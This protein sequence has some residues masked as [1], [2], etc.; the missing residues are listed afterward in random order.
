MVFSTIMKAKLPGNPSSIVYGIYLCSGIILLNLFS[1]VI[2]K[3][4]TV[5][6]RN[7][8]IMKNKVPKNILIVNNISNKCC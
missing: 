4:V 6:L 8:N 3:S 5:F 2:T 7:A 1:E